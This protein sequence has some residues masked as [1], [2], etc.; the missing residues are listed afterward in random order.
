MTTNRGHGPGE[1]KK[2]I[3]APCDRKPLVPSLLLLRLIKREP[4]LYHVLKRKLYDGVGE[5]RGKKSTPNMGRSVQS[6]G[7]EETNQ[8]HYKGG[9]EEVPW[10]LGENSLV[11]GCGRK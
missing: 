8:S 11:G 6:R 1:R 10:V 3:P 2:I 4:K 5:K 9:E 7:R